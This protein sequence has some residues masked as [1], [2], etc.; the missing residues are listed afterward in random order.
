MQ[1]ARDV[2]DV[3]RERRPNMALLEEI[4]EAERRR[5]ALTTIVEVLEII[6][7]PD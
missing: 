2:L 6:R 7:L 1:A 4:V 3:P 5:D